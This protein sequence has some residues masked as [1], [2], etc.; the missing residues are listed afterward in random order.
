MVTTIRVVG[1]S[2][3]RSRT[4]VAVT[5]GRTTQAVTKGLPHVSR[6]NPD[7]AFLFGT[8]HD[9]RVIVVDADRYGSALARDLHRVFPAATVVAISQHADRRSMLRR[10]GIVTVPAAAPPAQIASLIARLVRS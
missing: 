5:G 4:I 8:H 3:S 10:T 6:L 1:T 7:H 9:V 2:A